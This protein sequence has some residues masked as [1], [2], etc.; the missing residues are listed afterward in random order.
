MKIEKL[1]DTQIRCTLNKNDLASRKI[2]ISE[3]AYGTEK[4]K[5][6]FRDM[7]QQASYEYG[8]EAD[9]LPLMIEA[10]PMSSESIVLIIT[11]VEDPEEL[12]TRFSRFSPSYD[13]EEE[14]E[15]D[16]YDD[17]DMDMG[18]TLLSPSTLNSGN[19]QRLSDI[20]EDVTAQTK[21]SDNSA[22]IRI[23]SFSDFPTVEKT[24]F[25]L[26]NCYYGENTLYKDQKNADFYLVLKKS[27]H[28]SDEFNRIC[29]TISEYGLRIP[30]S[31][32]R[33]A[34]FIEHYQPMIQ[35]SAL[36]TIGGIL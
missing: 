9:N 7:M 10:I 30:F 33:E 32:E 27:E 24:A 13:G 1:S 15:Y 22:T 25:L 2:K 36:Q 20:A 5:D 35:V 14:E 29:N 4:A 8:F 31:K 19:F 21:G 3:L 26:K 17:L 18:D 23:F 6:L 34:F 11:K 28:S 12:D 16:N